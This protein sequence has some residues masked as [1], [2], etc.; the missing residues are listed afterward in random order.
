MEHSHAAGGG[1]LSVG[2]VQVNIATCRNNIGI[3]TTAKWPDCCPSSSASGRLAHQDIC[4]PV[5]ADVSKSPDTAFFLSEQVV[6]LLNPVLREQLNENV[7]WTSLGRRLVGTVEIAVYWQLPSVEYKV[8]MCRNTIQRNSR[9]FSGEKQHFFLP[10]LEMLTL[11]QN[12]KTE[13]F[14]IM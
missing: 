14:H 5:L 11:Q 13:V 1:I 2:R 4:Y 3:K 7:K 6:C 9:G 8:G 10:T 12:Y